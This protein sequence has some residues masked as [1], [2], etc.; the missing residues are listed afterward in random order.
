LTT[1][2]P[3]HVLF[4]DGDGDELPSNSC[5]NPHMR[6]LINDVSRRQVLAGGASL[7]ALAFSGLACQVKARPANLPN[8][9]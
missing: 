3:E 7:G 9:V 8:T 1:N 5:D 2:N 6:E 4:G